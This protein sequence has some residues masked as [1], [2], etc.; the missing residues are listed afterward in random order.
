MRDWEAWN[1]PNLS[2]YLTPQWT[3]SK[4]PASPG[5]YRTLLN[6]FYKGLKSVAP[7]DVVAG[8]TTAPFGDPPGGDEPV[9]RQAYEADAADKQ[10]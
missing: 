2:T 10:A 9:R 3:A 5:I 1:E 6:A 7:Q 8:G 4:H